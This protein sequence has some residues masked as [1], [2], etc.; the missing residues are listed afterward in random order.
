MASFVKFKQFTMDLGI[1]VHDLRAG[2][3]TLKIYLSATAP[4]VD[5]Y[6]LKADLPGIVEE[7]GYLP[8]DV[9]NDFSLVDGVATMV[10]VNVTFTGTG[11]ALLGFG[12]FRYV[13][14]YNATTIVKVDP[15]I[16]F[17]D[18]GEEIVVLGTN[19][20]IVNFASLG[21]AVLTIT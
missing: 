10:G 6:T 8:A 5:L 3:D 20:Y 1:R 18:C 9:Q 2:G 12:P 19:E 11:S 4:D 15:L 13:V 16:G 21:T 14:L 7:Y 17:W